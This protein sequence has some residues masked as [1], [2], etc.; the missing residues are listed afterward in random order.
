VRP[1]D[2][3]AIDEDNHVAARTRDSYVSLMSDGY[4]DTLRLLVVVPRNPRPVDADLVET[5]LGS[6]NNQDLV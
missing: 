5:P 2:T 6:I 4:S 1:W 3:T